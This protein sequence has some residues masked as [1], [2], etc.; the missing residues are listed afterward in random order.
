MHYVPELADSWEVQ[1]E[2]KAYVFQLHKGVKFHDGTDFDAAAV[3]WNFARIMDPEK[4][5]PARQF[6][7]VVEAVEPLDTP[8]VKFTLKY[9]TQTLLPA[10]SAKNPLTMCAYAWPWVAT[11]SIARSSPRPR[12]WGSANRCGAL[13]RLVAR[14][15]STLPRSIPTSPRKP[16]PC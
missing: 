14:T 6:F 8:T 11:E 7:D 1:E 16:E 3:A 10:L 5:A 9:P 4:Q 13:S 12:S 2:G 15:T